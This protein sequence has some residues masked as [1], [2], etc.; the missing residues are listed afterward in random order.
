M[1]STTYYSTQRWIWILLK[2]Y[3]LSIFSGR[4]TGVVIAT[5][6]DTYCGILPLIQYCMRS[7]NNQKQSNE[8]QWVVKRGTEYWIYYTIPD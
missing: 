7:S 3:I 5:A 8:K 6:G 4:N 2:L 1:Q